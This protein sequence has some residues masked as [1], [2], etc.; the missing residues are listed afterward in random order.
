MERWSGSEMA[1]PGCFMDSLRYNQALQQGLLKQECVCVCV[2]PGGFKLKWKNGLPSFL[3][4]CCHCS[5]QYILCIMSCDLTQKCN[6]LNSHLYHSNLISFLSCS[7]P[8]PLSPYLS[9][10]VLNLFTHHLFLIIY[11]RNMFLE[12]VDKKISSQKYSHNK[13]QL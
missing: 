7:L 3:L 6:T 1:R 2:C 9:I 5:S 4:S 10:F 12:M 11:H 8:L 13:I